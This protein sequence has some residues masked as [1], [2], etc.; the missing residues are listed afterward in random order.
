MARNINIRTGQNPFYIQ[1]A[2]DFSQGL[3]GLQ[4][5]LEIKQ[6]RDDYDQEKSE[7][8]ERAA[9]AAKA[10]LAAYKTNDPDKI[11]EAIIEFPE[12]AGTLGPLY[13]KRRDYDKEEYVKALEGDLTEIEKTGALTPKTSEKR[14]YDPR[15]GISGGIG[16]AYPGEYDPAEFG[17]SGKP[18]SK[19]TQKI[20][21]LRSIYAQDPE[22]G[23]R[24]LEYDFAKLDPKRYEAWKDIYRP[25][26]KEETPS[27][28]KKMM[29]ERDTLKA[30][31]TESGMSPENI[32]K[33][34]DIIDFQNKISGKQGG[35]ERVSPHLRLINER[36]NYAKSLLD[37]GMSPEDIVKD[38][39]YISWNRKI[40]GEDK[41][42][43]PTS[44]RK[45]MLEREDLKAKLREEG[46]TEDQII[47]HPDVI[48][49]DDQ[50]SG[51]DTVI[52]GMWSQDKIDVWGAMANLNNG[53]I[54]SVG[55]GKNAGLLRQLIAISA[56]TQA[57]GNPQF[58]GKPG[59]S[60]SQGALNVVA[61]SLDTKAIG[62]AITQLHKQIAA[63][64]SFVQNMDKQIE[65]VS[66]M[67]EDLFLF[68][69]RILNIP[70]RFIRQKILGNPDLVQYDMILKDLARETSKLAGGA[71]QSIAA[72]SVDEIKE[73]DKIH[74]KNLSI[75]DM[76]QV[77][78]KTRRVAQIRLDSVKDEL[79]RNR[80]RARTRDYGGK[81][82]YPEISSQE[83]YNDLESG[84]KYTNPKYPGKTMVKP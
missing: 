10:A 48:S 15:E 56:A 7:K 8:K 83:A 59:L 79:E 1:P 42:W 37:S 39:D 28:L 29:N 69:V 51:Y 67:S 72:M 32:A 27:A 3:H 20:D 64:G 76:L 16:G 13:D 68:D 12:I 62:T 52:R 65:E 38:P 43:A 49:Y 35:E 22:A 9:E 23:K 77:L 70:Y 31:L 45:L 34:Q 14:L 57:L 24:A 25:D 47:E 66:T 21:I 71:T 58:G 63:M 55:R 73:W 18:G 54:P 75:E 40:M 4:R 5:G 82:A 50:I 74:D 11:A 41:T 36:D 17:I 6:N 2:G 33:N 30:K 26:E 84:D 46:L 60:P 80:A 78:R 44:H 61:M 53:K 81:E 19:M